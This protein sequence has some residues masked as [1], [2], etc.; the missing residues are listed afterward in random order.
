[1]GIERCDCSLYYIGKMR[2]YED[3]LLWEWKFVV[4][5]EET[6]AAMACTW[7]NIFA[8]LTKFCS[9]WLTNSSFFIHG[10]LDLGVSVKLSLLKLHSFLRRLRGCIIFFFSKNKI[11]GRYISEIKYV[12][13]HHYWS[14][15]NS[16]YMF[17][18]N[19]IIVP[20]M[21]D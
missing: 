21:L 9:V 10:W 14:R 4:F 7:R 18:V 20:A 13:I 12:N 11:L 6:G 15:H 16:N 8:L 1:M 17:Y 19:D 5:V 2:C 3:K